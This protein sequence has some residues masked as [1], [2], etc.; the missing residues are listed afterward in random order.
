MIV[1]MAL[2]AASRICLLACRKRSRRLRSQA[3]ARMALFRSRSVGCLI[4]RCPWSLA[5]MAR[6]NQIA[7]LPA[8]KLIRIIQYFKLVARQTTACN[9]LTPAIDALSKCGMGRP[10]KPGT[11]RPQ[12][13][14]GKKSVVTYL[15]IPKWRELRVVAVLNDMTLDA[16]L[17]IGADLVIEK[18]KNKRAT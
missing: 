9:S 18:F 13:R 1:R 7:Q 14:R 17:Q 15:P 11:I 10:P 16:L 6:P 12:S 8:V 5:A 4:C 3:T 2:S